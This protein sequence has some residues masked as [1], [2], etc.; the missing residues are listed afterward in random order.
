MR[1]FLDLTAPAAGSFPLCPPQDLLE[2]T[3][4][5]ALAEPPTVCQVLFR[6]LGLQSRWR[7]CFRGSSR[8]V[9]VPV[10]PLQPPGCTYFPG[11]HFPEGQRRQSTERPRPEVPAGLGRAG[12][13]SASSCCGLPASARLAAAAAPGRMWGL[14]CGGAACFPGFIWHHF[15]PVLALTPQFLEL[16]PSCMGAF[17]THCFPCLSSC[18]QLLFAPPADLVPLLP[19]SPP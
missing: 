16:A 10:G 15:L 4:S 9:L 3:Q 7:P 5:A 18:G 14:G 12:L 13:G 19:G 1:G 11:P 17:R 6:G 8:A 2:Q